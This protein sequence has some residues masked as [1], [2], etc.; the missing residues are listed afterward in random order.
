MFTHVGEKGVD[1][2]LPSSTSAISIANFVASSGVSENNFRKDQ[3]SASLW[4][5]HKIS[6][7]LSQLLRWV[8]A[9]KK[10]LHLLAIKKDHCA[11]ALTASPR[12][13]HCRSVTNGD[14]GDGQQT[15]AAVAEFKGKCGRIDLG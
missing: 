8:T 10:E 3:N 14:S 5:Y 15:D 13:H 4:P 1:F 11:N 12:I 2:F 9:I 6:N 7:E